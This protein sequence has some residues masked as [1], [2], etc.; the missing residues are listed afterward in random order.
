M[1]IVW[2][3]SPEEI[4]ASSVQ[5][6]HVIRCVGSVI[7]NGF[8][9][10]IIGSV[11]TSAPIAIGVLATKTLTAATIGA[12]FSPALP[13]IALF[14]AAGAAACGLA[15]MMGKEQGDYTRRRLME[16]AGLGSLA[17]SAFS[18]GLI[19]PV[20]R[21]IL[22]GAGYKLLLKYA[23]LKA[24]PFAKAAAIGGVSAYSLLRL[25]TDKC[26]KPAPGPR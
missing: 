14:A 8:A 15:R 4:E 16:F 6:Q 19:L 7:K 17:A 26:F 18:S 23:V 12:A 20:V 3:W 11:A 24:M 21:G 1:G 10:G 13:V 9:G 2:G 25:Y 22:A 5:P